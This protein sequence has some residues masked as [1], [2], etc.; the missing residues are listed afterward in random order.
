MVSRSAAALALGALLIAACSSG[1]APSQS[2][3]G[4]SPSAAAGDGS[5][6]RVKDAGTLKICA[7]D[8]LLPYSSSDPAVPGFE[9][10]IGQAVAKQL[11]VKAEHAWGS[12][13]GLIPMLTSKQCDTI[14]DGLFITDER[15]KTVDF[16]GEEYASGEAIL[17]PESDTTVKGLDDLKDKKIGVLSGSVTVQLL[18]K[19]G[20]KDN[21]QIYPDQN[22]IILELNNGRID[23]AFLEAPSAAW[24]LEQDESLNLKLVEEYVP[25]ERFDA[26]AAVRKEDNDLEAA[27]RDA[28]AELRADGTIEEILSKYGVPF[29]PIN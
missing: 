16:A 2:A 14:I 6:Q 26:G 27:I 3:V 13:D 23:A 8:G 17:V 21:L 1:A 5:L 24:A 10:E 20:F 28:L 11:G 15:K 29:Y 25:E 9:V 18:E 19:A 4:G 7:V 22:T 12:W